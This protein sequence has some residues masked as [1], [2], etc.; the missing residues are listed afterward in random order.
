[1]GNQVT[2]RRLPRAMNRNMKYTDIDDSM[3]TDRPL[4]EY[5]T[6]QTWGNIQE[7]CPYGWVFSLGACITSTCALLVIIGLFLWLTIRGAI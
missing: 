7:G 1:M 4:D 3:E 6:V 5:E 2:T